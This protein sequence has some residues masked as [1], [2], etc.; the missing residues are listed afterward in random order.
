MKRILTLTL[1]SALLCSCESGIESQLI[2]TWENTTLNVQT[3]SA[4]GQDTT[5]YLTIEQGQWEAA[6]NIKPI[7]TTYLEDGSFKSEY[8]G[9]DGKPVGKEEGTWKIR[10][11]SLI[12]KSGGYD[13]VYKVTFAGDSARFVSYLDWDQDG[14]PDDLYDGWQVKIKD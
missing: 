1:I 4:G 13:N 11:D 14:A 5:V 6:L 2:G 10:N 3:N 9:L 8:F 7:V 12:L